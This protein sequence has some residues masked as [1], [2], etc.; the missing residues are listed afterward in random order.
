MD[1]YGSLLAPIYAMVDELTRKKMQ[2]PSRF[3]WKHGFL[4]NLE[5]GL[6]HRNDLKNESTKRNMAEQGLSAPRMQNQP[7]Q[8]SP[9]SN[10][11]ANAA[12]HS[13]ST[14][15]APLPPSPCSKPPASKPGLHMLH[16]LTCPHWPTPMQPSTTPSKCHTYNDGHIH[17]ASPI[18]GLPPLE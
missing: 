9:M 2:L 4:V 18:Q 10:K 11:P 13:I 12:K 17:H 14:K 5:Q 15:S 6:H 16:K 8:F 3:S 1:L 7:Q